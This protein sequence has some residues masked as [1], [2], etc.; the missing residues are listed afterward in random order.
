MSYFV[1]MAACSDLSCMDYQNPKPYWARLES[2]R[3]V[4]HAPRAKLTE[5]GKIPDAS[6][7]AGVSIEKKIHKLL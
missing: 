3:L 5:D 2:E 7:V 4:A 1:L 6:Q